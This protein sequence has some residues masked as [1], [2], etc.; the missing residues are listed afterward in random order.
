MVN[1]QE[2]DG[3]HYRRALD[4]LIRYNPLQL[5]EGELA[6]G[7]DAWSC[8]V[9]SKEAPAVGFMGFDLRLRGVPSGRAHIFD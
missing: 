9:A 5:A 3:F 4:P 7:H 6:R 1:C 2:W 8:S